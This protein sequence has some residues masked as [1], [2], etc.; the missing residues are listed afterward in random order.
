MFIPAVPPTAEPGATLV[1]TGVKRAARWQADSED[2]GSTTRTVKKG[3]VDERESGREEGSEQHKEKL[4]KI[5]VQLEYKISRIT[6]NLDVVRALESIILLSFTQVDTPDIDTPPRVIGLVE[7]LRAYLTHGSRLHDI[8]LLVSYLH[9][10]LTP[11]DLPPSVDS[12]RPKFQLEWKKIKNEY[13]A[14]WKLCKAGKLVELE[15]VRITDPFQHPPKPNS[16]SV[17]VFARALLAEAA[18]PNVLVRV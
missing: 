18:G 6:N 13:P 12:L 2:E 15:P 7:G 16:R 5:S 4:R 17:W 10:L 8:F 11:S 9:D 14:T 3:R 1:S